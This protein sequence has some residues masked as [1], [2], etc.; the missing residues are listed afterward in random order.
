MVRKK[1]EGWDGRLIYLFLLSLINKQSFYFFLSYLFFVTRLTKFLSFLSWLTGTKKSLFLSNLE[2][3]ENKFFRMLD[4]SVYRRNTL[5]GFF[6]FPTIFLK[7]K[8]TGPKDGQYPG[9][10]H[11]H[12]RTMTADTAAV[13]AKTSRR[14]P[15]PQKSALAR[16]LPWNDKAG[17]FSP[18]KAIT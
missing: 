14:P 7:T 8:K 2:N 13:P 9:V 17:R 18:L 11:N 1:R 3:L 16:K 4:R 6:F 15:P 5:I 10:N 12:R